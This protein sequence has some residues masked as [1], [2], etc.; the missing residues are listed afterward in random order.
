[1]ESVVH[2]NRER[3]LPE[4]KKVLTDR[5]ILLETKKKEG[6]SA[7]SHFSD[8][9]AVNFEH[10]HFKC[11]RAWKRQGLCFQLVSTEGNLKE[12]ETKRTNTHT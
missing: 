3:C 2:R 8:D 7:M 6:W 10:F 4:I 12:M 9:M 5:N 11:K 1:M